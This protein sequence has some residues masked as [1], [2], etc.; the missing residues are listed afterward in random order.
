MPKAE[1]P[2]E[3]QQGLQ[4]SHSFPESIFLNTVY[5]PLKASI[6]RFKTTTTKQNKKPLIYED[7]TISNLHKLPNPQ[8][9][10]RKY[11]YSPNHFYQ[12]GNRFREIR[13]MED[14]TV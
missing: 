6:S 2:G 8:N 10:L 9:H 4:H 11:H 7:T 1:E 12:L 13:D 3:V 5:L 14:H